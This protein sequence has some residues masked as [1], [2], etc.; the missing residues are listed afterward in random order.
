M[1]MIDSE[2]CL[3][4]RQ[5][6][7]LTLVMLLLS[8]HLPAQDSNKQPAPRPSGLKIYILEGKGVVNFIPDKQAATPVVEV[9]DDNGFPVSGATVEFHLPETGPG[10]DFPNGQHTFSAVTN[11]AGQAEAPFTV[12]QQPGSFSIQVSAKIDTRSGSV[13]I[14]QANSLKASEAAKTTTKPHHWYKNWKILAIAGAGVVA[15]VVVLATRGG[16]GSGSGTTVGLTPG[17]PTFG[18]PH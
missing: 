2:H 3:L 9:R 4:P 11:T 1:A 15:L 17:V 16:G 14:M 8:S 12:R 7:S 10:G 13:V 5:F 18:A 6:L